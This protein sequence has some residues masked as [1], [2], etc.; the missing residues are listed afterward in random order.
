VFPFYELCAA[1]QDLR[2]GRA[3]DVE[4]AR[5]RITAQLDTLRTH[6]LRYAVL[7]AFGCGAFR[8]PPDIVA[9]IYEEE[10]NKRERD[11][12]VARVRDPCI[13]LRTG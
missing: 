6:R 2:D 13:G 7:G 3:L 12:L 9:R 4:D 1:A 10:I 8:K 5:R 11:F